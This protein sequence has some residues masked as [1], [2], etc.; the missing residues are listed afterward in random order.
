MKP[1]SQRQREVVVAIAN[2]GSRKGIAGMMG[3][4]THTIDDYLK[5]IR[6]KVGFSDVALLT[7]WAIRQGMIVPLLLASWCAAADVSL[8]WG[9]SPD[10][11]VGYRVY[12]RTVGP[13]EAGTTS[14][15]DVGAST[16]ATIGPLEAGSTWDFWVTAYDATCLES[17]PT[18]VVTYTVPLI[19]TAV[20]ESSTDLVWWDTLVAT[21]ATA[22]GTNPAAF[23]RARMEIR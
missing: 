18:G 17:D 23:Y 3:V 12:Y 15:L 8:H 1:L 11:C 10:P 16:N 13:A 21:T 2:G 4:T 14:C 22:I 9:P 7:R 19:V 5:R 6:A 20:V